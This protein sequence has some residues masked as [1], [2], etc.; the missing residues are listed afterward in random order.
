VV[1][2]DL[3]FTERQLAPNIFRRRFFPSNA[4]EMAWHQD[5]ENRTVLIEGGSGWMLQLDNELPMILVQG[6]TYKIPR[7]V[8]HRLLVTEQATELT[9][10]ISKEY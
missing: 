1:T 10:T 6:K 8:W 7:F 9:V 5:P 3:P 4:E 2:L